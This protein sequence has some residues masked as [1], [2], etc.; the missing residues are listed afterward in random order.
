M[1]LTFA[2]EF[3]SLRLQTQGV[4]SG[5]ATAYDWDRYSTLSAHTISGEAEVYVDPGFGGSALAALG[6]SP[7]SIDNGVLT[8]TAAQTPDWAKAA[9]WNHDYTS[10][11]ITTKGAFAQTYGYFEMR[12]DLPAGQGV[13]PAFWLLPEDGSYSSELDIVET[14]NVEN[15]VY[16]TVHTPAGGDGV[17][18]NTVIPD[19]TVGFHTFGVLWSPQTITWYVDGAAVSSTDTPAAMNKPMYILANFAVGGSWAGAPNPAAFPAE[20]KI[21]YIRAYSLDGAPV[22]APAEGMRQ[23][24]GADANDVISD[25]GSGAYIRG[26]AGDD[27]LT[28]GPGFD[29]ING[30]T[31]DDTVSGGAGDDWVVGGK[32]QDLLSGDQGDDIVY[33]NLGN[34]WCDGGDGNDLIRGGQGDDV[35]LGQAGNDW[36]SGDRGNDTLIGGTGADTFHT[37]G[38]AGIDRVT[39]FNPAEGDRVQ[40]DSGTTYTVAQVGADTVIN[41]DGGGQMILV[42][43][44]MASLTGAWIFEA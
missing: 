43:V 15:R 14:V 6:I 35:L 37:S 25:D 13:F 4:A 30:N 29:D 18:F 31:G 21:D 24:I 9:L 19:L 1:P 42:G 23:L 40:L 39:D 11:L 26:G 27:R 20:M 7:F 2:D 38:D 16:T 36:L 17:G 8:I 3:D 10:G 33:G 44:S 41:M 32:D 12:A 5:W 28:G 22:A 34:D